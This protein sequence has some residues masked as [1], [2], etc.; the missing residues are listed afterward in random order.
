[1]SLKRALEPE[2]RS[3]KAPRIGLEA[4]E[5]RRESHRLTLKKAGELL[6]S[7]RALD[8]EKLL[9]ANYH[10]I[11]TNTKSNRLSWYYNL[12]IKDEML[13]KKAIYNI[14]E[15]QTRKFT[16]N[17]SFAY[18]LRNSL[19]GEL[20]FYYASPGNS[21][22]KLTIPI[23]NISDF[24]KF[25]KTLQGV[26]LAE[27]ARLRRP[28]SAWKVVTVLAITFF[29]M[30]FDTQLLGCRAIRLPYWAKRAKYLRTFMEEEGAR[31]DMKC[32]FRCLSY[33]KHGDL[34]MVDEYADQYSE[35]I[36]EP[37]EGFSLSDLPLIEKHFNI[38]IHVMGKKNNIA[39]YEINPSKTDFPLNMYLDLCETH[40]SLI[41][42]IDEYTSTFKCKTCFRIFNRKDNFKRHTFINCKPSVDNIKFPSC[43]A[44][45]FKVFKSV[46][47]QVVDLGFD[48]EPF[49][50]NFIVFDFESVLRKVKLSTSKMSFSQEHIPV[51]YSIYAEIDGVGETHTKIADALPDDMPDADKLLGDFHQTLCDISEKAFKLPSFMRELKQINPVL[52]KQF[53]TRLKQIPVVSFNG[54]K[55]DLNL[56]RPFYFP[57]IIG[58]KCIKRGGKY[59]K[60]FTKNYAMYDIIN[61]IAPGFSL[62]K[63]LKAY[64]MPLVKGHFPYSYLSS[65]SQLDQTFLPSQE[66]F[67]NDLK[68]I[69]LPDED[70]AECQRVFNE[71]VP[72]NMRSYLKYYNEL[73][74]V[75][76]H[77]VIKKMNDFYN[78][79]CYGVDMFNDGLGIPGLAQKIMMRLVDEDITFHVL[80]KSN[81]DLYEKIRDQITGGPSIVFCRYQEAGKTLIRNNPSKPCKRI[82]GYDAASLYLSTMNKEYPTGIPVRRRAENNFKP[83]VYLRGYKAGEYLTWWEDRVNRNLPLKEHIKIQSAFHKGEYKVEGMFSSGKSRD[84]KKPAKS[85]FRHNFVD[86]YYIDSNGQENILEFHGCYWHG[87]PKCFWDRYDK[88]GIDAPDVDPLDD[89]FNS[90][91]KQKFERTK[92]KQR[93]IESITKDIDG[94]QVPRYKYR[95]MWE[96]E[97]NGTGSQELIELLEEKL[98]YPHHNETLTEEK[99][100]DYVKDGSI[101]G[102]IECKIKV[103]KHLRKAFADFQP[104]FLNKKVGTSAAEIGEY[105]HNFAETHKLPRAKQRTLIASFKAKKILLATPLAQWY[106]SHGLIITRV[107]E[108][109]QYRPIACFKTFVEKVTKHRR[110]GDVHT[111]LKIIGETFKLIGNSC[112][113][114]FA[115]CLENYDDVKIMDYPKA[116]KV[117]EK[118]NFKS[119][120][121]FEKCCEMTLKPDSI[122]MN[123]PIHLAHFTYQ[124]AKLRMLEFFYDCVSH[125][126]DSSDFQLCT[127]DTDSNYYAISGDCFDDLVIPELKEEYLLD[128]ENWFPS[129]ASPEAFKYSSR[130]G[131]LFKLEFEANFILALNSKS[132]IATGFPDEDGKIEIKTGQK[133]VNKWN[134]LQKGDYQKVL[135]TK[136]PHSVVNRGFMRK[137]GSI[138]TYALT[139][140]ALTY[141]Y[142]KRRVE[143]DGYTTLPTNL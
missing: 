127:M 53:L 57:H 56:I 38:G 12:Q 135:D 20:K 133:G 78:T 97:W 140:N 41:T 107:F 75:P 3:V 71:L 19:T 55:Y 49:T 76:L 82:V 28:S 119:V 104:L 141:L 65:V 134:Q 11:R 90:M 92:E 132:Y 45:S 96:H 131:G 39:W 27:Q 91:M 128:R 115:C 34:S 4:F 80:D 105:M 98:Y 42:D 33:F 112:Y 60:I 94:V 46:F 10:I 14:F 100:I 25:Y 1:L 121:E 44:T 110:E 73:D 62:D 102:F 63:L 95:E 5:V 108:I 6:D 2:Q 85:Y 52:Y 84:D 126:L 23:N 89:E 47:Q 18:I 72:K 69:D 29:L 136:E 17:Y 93:F 58:S 122:F 83:E 103:P 35:L 31:T 8:V 114:R 118:P 81:R 30:K 109:V 43:V 129:N 16:L 113:G 13:D 7:S 59:L 67:R 36:N 15:Q 130:I 111:D 88:D 21:V 50:K 123:L 54:G 138:H 99:I 37:F 48:F 9:K 142:K 61:Y 68:D 143:P 74:V 87:C 22:L 70:Y 139:K 26:D 86:G 51:S 124:Y 79:H 40:L 101:F 66:E 77:G 137:N 64:K 120:E 32:F 125:Y 24:N 117:K 116:N 106:L